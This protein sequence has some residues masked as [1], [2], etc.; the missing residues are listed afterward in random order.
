[1][2][3]MEHM[4]LYAWVS[5]HLGYNSCPNCCTRSPIVSYHPIISKAAIYHTL[6]TYGI[7]ATDIHVSEIIDKITDELTDELPAHFKAPRLRAHAPTPVRSRQI[8]MYS[9]SLSS[10]TNHKGHQTYALSRKDPGLA[11]G[12]GRRA[13]QQLDKSLV[14]SLVPSTD[15]TCR[16]TDAGMWAPVI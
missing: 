15:A 2:Q 16:A 4:L 12:E 6:E 7:L 10:H 9:N 5:L 13:D 11:G 8:I 3:L 1:M 14:A